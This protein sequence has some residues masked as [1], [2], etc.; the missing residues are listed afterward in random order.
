M[1]FPAI[2]VGLAVYFCGERKVENVYTWEIFEYVPFCFALV[3]RLLFDIKKQFHV[4]ISRHNMKHETIIKILFNAFL[5]NDFFSDVWQSHYFK[6]LIDIWR[7]I[8]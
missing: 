5:R 7:L 3:F 2:A 6:S 8:K 1:T 4:C